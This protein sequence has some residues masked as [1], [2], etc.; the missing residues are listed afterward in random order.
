MLSAA[1]VSESGQHGTGGGGLKQSF[2]YR[3]GRLGAWVYRFDRRGQRRFPQQEWT[4][5]N[6]LAILA[7]R[8]DLWLVD[9]SSL[10]SAR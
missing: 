5:I 6:G 1:C 9:Q 3:H 8:Q 2:L 10:N 7:G 4:M